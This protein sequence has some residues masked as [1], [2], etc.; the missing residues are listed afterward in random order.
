MAVMSTDGLFVRVNDKLCEMT[1]RAAMELSGRSIFDC[2]VEEDRL[3]AMEHATQ[4]ISGKHLEPMDVRYPAP[5]GEV[6]WARVSVTLNSDE[7]QVVAQIQD[8]TDHHLFAEMLDVEAHRN[9]REMDL[10]ARVQRSLLPDMGHDWRGFDVGGHCVP[11]ASVGGDYFDVL[12]TQGGAG[13]YLV[14]GDV[15]GHSLAS[16]MMT[17]VTRAAMRR[18]IEAGV[19]PSLAL[20]GAAETAAPDLEAAES[21]VTVQC[22]LLDRS[23]MTASVAS[24]GHNAL[25][26]VRGNGGVEMHDVDGMPF[27]FPAAI[28]Y[29]ESQIDLEPGDIVVLY[30]DGIT[31][32]RD[33][34]GEM[35][36][37]L[38]FGQLLGSLAGSKPGELVTQVYEALERYTG[39]TDW[40][41]DV[42]VLAA[43]IPAV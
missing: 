31:E 27:G 2:L 14:V 25:A 39:T 19:S 6:R 1:G 30:T 42:T 33:P 5:T 24:G 8:V 11:A 26:V 37:D 38:R 35:Y 43:S 34:Q 10:A 20:S 13:L 4:V 23:R 18:A 3:P 29:E 41:D 7:Q 16:S 15:A 28:P 22:V 36:G 17:T 40:D 9:A 32:A 21:F 12:E